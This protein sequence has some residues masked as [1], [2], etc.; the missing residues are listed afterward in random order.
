MI[1]INYFDKDNYESLFSNKVRQNIA[2]PQ[3][4]VLG[5]VLFLIYINELR[6]ALTEA[7]S[8]LN[9]DDTTLLVYEKISSYTC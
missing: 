3:G 9:A 5:L 1:K 7:F 4:S 6:R 8:Y 2:V